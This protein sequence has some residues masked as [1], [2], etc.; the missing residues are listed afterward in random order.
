MALVGTDRGTGTH[1]TGATS[2][3]LTVGG[4][5]AE[6]SIAVLIVAADN[7]S[8]GG[9]TNDFST[10]VDLSQGNSFQARQL[11]IFDNGAASAGVQ[12]IIATS[13]QHEGLLQSGQL[14][15]V[16]FGSSPV[17]K[18]WTLMEVKSDDPRKSVKFVQGANGTGAT[19]TTPTITTG[20]ITNTNMVIAAIFNE[21]GTG[22]TITQDGDA[23]NGT[24]STQQTA[25][26]G[27]TATGMSVASQRK[28]VTASA[29][30]TYNPTLG[31]SSDLIMSWIELTEAEYPDPGSMR[32]LQG[33]PLAVFAAADAGICK[34]GTTTLEAAIADLPMVI[35]YRVHAISS[36]I[37]HRLVRVPWVGLVNLV[38]GYEVA[39]EFLQRRATGE[40][41]A[42]GVLPLL[43][44]DNPITRRQREGLHLVRERLGAP[45]AA[46]RVAALATGLLA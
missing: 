23:T 11:P 1:N 44:A 32:V 15:S 35:T 28:V 22:Q 25:E 9:S 20:S 2:F 16:S 10:I 19:T 17:A 33:D 37:A 13:E 36:F 7:S 41:L 29:T 34:S 43:D 5:F 24:W 21:Q 3:N 4:N 14:I 31:V 38:A 30:Q 46:D 6:G 39:P 26:I 45:G 27:T 12:G 8:S 18:A 42:S 40:A